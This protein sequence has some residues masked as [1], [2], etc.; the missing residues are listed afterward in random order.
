MAPFTFTEIG[1]STTGG[2][3]LAW[4]SSLTP[5]GRT[6]RDYRWA[7]DWAAGAAEGRVWPMSLV[8]GVRASLEVTDVVRSIEFYRRALGFEPVATMGEPPAFAILDA[9]GAGLAI[10]E[11]AHPAVARIAACYVDVVDVDAAH[12][13]CVQAGIP[14]VMALMT[15]PWPKRDFVVRDPDGHQIAIGQ[16]VAANK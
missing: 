3:L 4:L 1:T 16:D 8:L 11:E 9:G 6:G 7:S 5:L 13:R 12:E 14:V 15:H 2:L 10:A